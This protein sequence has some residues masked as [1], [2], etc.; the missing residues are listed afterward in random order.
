MKTKVIEIRD[1]ATCI[2]AVAIKMEA[3]NIVEDR[4]LWRCGY[5]RDGSGIVLMHLY[6]QR[7]NSDPYGFGDRTMKAAHLYIY[8]H[9]DELRDGDVVD[10]RV[11]LNEADEPAEPE[12]W[13][14]GNAA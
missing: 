6:D 11:L 9:W 1:R 10:V 4:F 13:T 7:A 12:I 5:P 8:D 2:P 3:A 14:E